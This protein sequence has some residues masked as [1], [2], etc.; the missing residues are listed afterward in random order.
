LA[1][2]GYIVVAV[3]WL[4][5]GLISVYPTYGY[6]GYEI[7]GDRWLGNNSRG[8]RSL[9]VVTNDGSTEVIEW[10]QDNVQAGSVVVSY[11]DDPHI[12]NYL[13]MIQPFTFELT[14]AS[15]FQERDEL[16]EEL[17]RANYVIA[18]PIYD[19]DFVVPLTDSFFNEFFHSEPVHQI[20]RGRGM[21][22]MSIM[23][24]YHID[25]E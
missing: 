22:K 8:H 17:E 12:V 3:G 20:F 24:I 4:I 15:Q 18:R 23:Q 10:L 21:Y 19:I 7:V 13:N 1:W 9:V 11:L 2:S 16:I 6:F 5:V 14:Y 25:N